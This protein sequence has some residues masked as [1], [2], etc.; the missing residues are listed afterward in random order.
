MDTNYKHL[1]CGDNKIV[2]TDKCYISY[3][4]KQTYKS[5]NLKKNVSN[6]FV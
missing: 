4:K 6:A 3:K 5:V 2:I 1:S